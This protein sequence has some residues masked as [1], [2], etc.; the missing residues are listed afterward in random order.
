MT[1]LLLAL[2]LFLLVFAIAQIIRIY[3]LSVKASNRDEYVVTNK[4]N[5]NQGR[6]MLVFGIALLVL[7]CCDGSC[8]EPFSSSRSLR[9]Y[10]VLKLIGYGM[11]PWG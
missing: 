9:H 10:M 2:V 1:G 7:F 3:E 6:L 4:D 11:F 5:S 8:L